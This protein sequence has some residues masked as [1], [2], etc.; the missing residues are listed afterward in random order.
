[1]FALI[2]CT[3]FNDRPTVAQLPDDETVKSLAQKIGPCECPIC[4]PCSHVEFS[5]G[6]YWESLG[7]F[8]TEDEAYEERT[9]IEEEREDMAN[10]YPEESR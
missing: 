2:K 1:M 4:G 9:R 5:F 10:A 8:E 7:T 3:K 6:G